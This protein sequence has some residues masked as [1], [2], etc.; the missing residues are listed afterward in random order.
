M[1]RVN[2]AELRAWLRE[3]EE[4]DDSGRTAM[5]LNV[6]D[7]RRRALSSHQPSAGSLARPA[8]SG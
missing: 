5:R 2:A 6:S 3:I 7:V 1:V 8:V 4:Q